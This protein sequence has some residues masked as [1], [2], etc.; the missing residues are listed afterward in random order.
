[1]STNATVEPTSGKALILTSG[2]TTPSVMMEFENTC[3]DFFE[4]K[5]VPA[6]KQVTFIV[7]GIRDLCIQ[8]WV[9]ADRATIV[10]VTHY[11]CVKCGSCR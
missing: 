7:P 9:A 4:V 5:S 10:A 8:N 2:D 6:E 11:L 3:Y 1:M